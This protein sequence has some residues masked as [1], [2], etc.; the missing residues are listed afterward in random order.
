[1]PIVVCA[2]LGRAEDGAHGVL[3]LEKM[4]GIHSTDS[5]VLDGGGRAG[6]Q[7]QL[8]CSPEKYFT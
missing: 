5:E 7:F 4:A 2:H 1:M 8:R 6:V 3:E